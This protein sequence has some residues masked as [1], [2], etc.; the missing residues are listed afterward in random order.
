MQYNSIGAGVEQDHAVTAMSLVQPSRANKLWEIPGCSRFQGH[1]ARL[2]HLVSSA[3]CL[4]HS[5]FLCLQNLSFLERPATTK[6]AAIRSV[7]PSE[8]KLIRS[9][10]RLRNLA[11]WGTAYPIQS[12]FSSVGLGRPPRELPSLRFPC[13]PK[14]P[15]QG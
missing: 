10:G 12:Q 15:L 2:L 5:L 11:S 14:M 13:N 4:P 1:L 3:R 7:K 8:I 9:M 6:P